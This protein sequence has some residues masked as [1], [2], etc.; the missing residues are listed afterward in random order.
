MTPPCEGRSA[1]RGGTIPIAD[2][3]ELVRRKNAVDAAIAAIVGRPALMS[4]VGEY[5]AS[6]VFGIALEASASGRWID[7]HFADGPLRG[8]SVN[9]KWYG[10]RDGV[11]DLHPSGGPDFYLVM[12]GPKGP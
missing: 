8:R 2:L 10:Q 5:V 4:H 12:T 1:K 6:Q 3:A 11:L 7:G 9:V